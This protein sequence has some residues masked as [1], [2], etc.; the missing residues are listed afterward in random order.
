MGAEPSRRK[1]L[2]VWGQSPQR[3]KILQ[4]LCNNNLSLGLV[5]KRLLLLERGIESSTAKTGLNWL[6]NGQQ[7]LG[8]G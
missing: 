7:D 3:S 6:H 8:D 4:F 1:P 5:W 2:G